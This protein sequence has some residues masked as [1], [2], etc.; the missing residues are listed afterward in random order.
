VKTAYCDGACR[1]GNPG[2]TS[3]AWV[4]YVEGK[5]AQHDSTYLGPERHTNNFSEYM[6][7]VLLLEYLYKQAIRNVVI[8]SDSSLVVNQVN[9]VWQI[10]DEDHRK[11]A[12]KCYGLLTQG[13]HVLK[14][15]D[16]HSGIVGNE[17]AD[18]LANEALDEAEITKP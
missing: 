6:A 14:H 16:G 15:C 17:R 11:T 1:G 18:K 3:S 9:Q 7:L 10:N 12:A 8:H 5:E 4:L 13:C 2:F